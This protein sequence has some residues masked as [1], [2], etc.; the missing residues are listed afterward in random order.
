[1]ARDRDLRAVLPVGMLFGFLV[2]LATSLAGSGGSFTFANFFI[3]LVSLGRPVVPPLYAALILAPAVAV[4]CSLLVYSTVPP[5]TGAVRLRV[6]LFL[7]LLSAVVGLAWVYA[8][9]STLPNSLLSFTVPG[10]ALVA[11]LWVYM[12]R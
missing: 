11:V 3:F 6:A 2:F 9:V 1:M 4:Y 5:A 8:A 12:R 7:P 10:L